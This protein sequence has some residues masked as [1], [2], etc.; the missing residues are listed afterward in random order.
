MLRS[1]DMTEKVVMLDPADDPELE[2]GL[3]TVII[4]AC[5]LD[6][7]FTDFLNIAAQAFLRGTNTVIKDKLVFQMEISTVEDPSKI[8]N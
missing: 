7:E 6:I 8:R 5:Q 4:R 2:E 1:V 3:R